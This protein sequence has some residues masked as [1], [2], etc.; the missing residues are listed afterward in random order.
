MF[1]TS[2]NWDSHVQQNHSFLAKIWSQATDFRSTSEI[3]D[4]EREHQ[5]QHQSTQTC[6]TVWRVII[7]SVT[8]SGEQSSNQILTRKNASKYS[9]EGQEGRAQLHSWKVYLLLKPSVQLVM[10]DEKY[11]SF[12]GDVPSNRPY[13]TNYPSTTPSHIRFKRRMKFAPKLFVWMAIS[14]KRISRVYVHR[15]KTAIGVKKYLNEC[16]RKRLAPFINRYHADDS[17]LFWPG[18]ASAHYA[19]EM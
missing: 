5:D 6:S 2:P 7:N 17:M 10:D 15:S 16:I 8:Y 13:Y 14:P 3:I 19:R 9:N 12:I 18:L 4:R 1:L 11:F